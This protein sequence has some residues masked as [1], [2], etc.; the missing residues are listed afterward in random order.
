M[1]VAA[2]ALI[3]NAAVVRTQILERVRTN[4]V[5]LRQAAAAHPAVE[6]LHADGGWSA[7]LRVPARK[8]EEELVL[9]LLDR[10]GVVVHPGFFFDFAREAFLVLSLLPETPVFDEGVA[11]I[12]DRAD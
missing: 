3:D 11:R 2:P 9:E 12:L 10:D 7:V 6:V 8:T 1:Q 5:R 4:Y